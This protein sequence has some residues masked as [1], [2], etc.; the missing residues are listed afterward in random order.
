MT[1][2]KRVLHDPIIFNGLYART[3]AFPPCCWC[4]E[5]KYLDTHN[6]DC[7]TNRRQRDFADRKSFQYFSLTSRRVGVVHFLRAYEPVR[8]CQS[9]ELS[10]GRERRINENMHG[11][12][13]F[14]YHHN[15]VCTRKEMGRP[16]SAFSSF[17]RRFS[18]SGRVEYS[19]HARF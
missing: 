7:M 8:E 15:Y 1:S 2:G 9:Y 12:K 3:L 19:I 5:F 6:E 13:R 18:D 16:T 10:V 11:F 17:D 4:C 14:K